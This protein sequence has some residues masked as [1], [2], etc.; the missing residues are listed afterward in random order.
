[1]GNLTFLN[2]KNFTISSRDLVY[3]PDEFNSLT[4]ILDQA[5][6]LHEFFETEKQTI[7]QATQSGYEAGYEN[8][9]SDG[10]EAALEHIATKL[11]VLAKEANDAR[12]EL[13]ESAGDIA[14]KI[15][16]K[17]AYD[18]GPKSTVAALAKTAAKDLT[19]NEP[20]VLR[21]NP[22]NAEYIQNELNTSSENSSAKITVSRDSTLSETDCVL[23]TEFGQIKADLTTQLNVLRANFYGS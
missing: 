13:R 10:Y 12:E 7:E 15:I 19:V 11:V 16:E 5:T 23:E 9:Q 8:G 22:D 6:H 4:S 18:I 21:V 3:Q 20:V 17:I 1:M 14:L 2:N